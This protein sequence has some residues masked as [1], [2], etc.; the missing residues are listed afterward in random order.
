MLGTA[1][2]ATSGTDYADLS[3]LAVAA[4]ATSAAVSLTPVDDLTAEGDETAI[5]SIQSVAGGSTTIGSNSS[6][7]ITITDE[8]SLTSSRAIRR[9]ISEAG[10]AV[11]AE[12][13]ADQLVLFD[14]TRRLTMLSQAR[15]QRLGTGPLGLLAEGVDFARSGG[16]SATVC[17]AD[18]ARFDE[19]AAEADDDHH[20]GRLGF[21][22]AGYDCLRN[23]RYFLDLEASFRRNQHGEDSFQTVAS[24]VREDADDFSTTTIGRFALAMV[25]ERDLHHRHR[26]S[27]R[28][29]GGNIGV[30]IVHRSAPGLMLDGSVS[31]GLA[32]NLFDFTTIITGSGSRAGG[33]YHFRDRFRSHNAMA[34]LGV[35][36]SSSIGAVEIEPALTL[37]ASIFGHNRID[38]RVR[39]DDVYYQGVVR[40]YRHSEV[41]LGFSPALS[42]RHDQHH[43]RLQPRLFC[44][45]SN[46]AADECGQGVVASHQVASRDGQ[47]RIS[48]QLEAEDF[49]G[50]QHHALVLNRRQLLFGS[51]AVSLVQT[52]GLDRRSAVADT[53]YRFGL[54]LDIRF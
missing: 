25:S 7:T 53:G 36:G 18:M 43:W 22:L 6:V 4:G 47:Q 14:S 12:L 27:I 45:N 49:R 29:Y 3:T 1:G 39:L 2:T 26:G 32:E 11:Q 16:A 20:H 48:L 33:R 35:S 10:V 5:I 34:T 37:Q 17:H 52:A 30:Y 24:L 46:K 13:T 23:Q 15:M 41:K 31:L 28:S 44:S 51:A 42:Y 54:Q 40:S 38:T 50:N 19:L 21:Q 9:R 8:A